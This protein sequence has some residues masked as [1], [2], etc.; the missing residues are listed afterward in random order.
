MVVRLNWLPAALE[1]AL[2]VG[3]ETYSENRAPHRRAAWNTGNGR[4]RV[5]PYAIFANEWRRI[6]EFLSNSD[7][8]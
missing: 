6:A 3:A 4:S 1:E 7:E 8:R 2:R 5:S